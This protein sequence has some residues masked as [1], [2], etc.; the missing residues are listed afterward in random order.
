[1]RI[2]LANPNTS[3]SVTDRIAAAARRA[4]SPGTEVVAVTATRG[5]PYIATRAE[6]AVGA[7]ALLELLAEHAGGADAVVVAAF[8]DPGLD[9]A[10]ELL[11]IP[12]VGMAEAALLTACMLGR[13]FAVVT[14]A[15]ALGTWYRDIVEHVGLGARCSG[16]HALGEPFDDVGTVAE[17]KAAKLVA[18]CREA[19][20]AGAEACILGG[21]PLA[22]L[23]E[24]VAAEVPVP[25]VDA[26]AAAL[27][28][29][30]TLAALR[31]RK[32]TVGGFR[33]P[34]PKP[35]TGLSEPMVR[36]FRGPAA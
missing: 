15:D 22:G 11:P 30:E 5:F 9:A 1:M 34:A 12:V 18:L 10:R 28:Q 16:I 27:R 35:T 20:A 24:V 17:E 19:A 14:F 13:R 4:A 33:H 29:A 8:G 31:P 2:L 3:R 23:A 21:A 7:V 26:A 32:A 6:A 25:L 36:L